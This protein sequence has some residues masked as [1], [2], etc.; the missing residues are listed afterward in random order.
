MRA[1]YTVPVYAPPELHTCGYFTAAWENGMARHAAGPIRLLDNDLTCHGRMYLADVLIGNW[2]VEGVLERRTPTE[3]VR[4][5]LAIAST[6][7]RVRHS[8]AIFPGHGYSRLDT[9]CAGLKTHATYGYF[10][11]AGLG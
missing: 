4:G 11:R 8:V 9:D 7:H 1:A 3:S 5:Q 10:V 2:F 6:R